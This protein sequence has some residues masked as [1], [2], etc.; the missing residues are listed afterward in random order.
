MQ[1]NQSETREQPA[2]APVSSPTTQTLIRTNIQ[3][4]DI[5]HHRGA[6]NIT[7]LK[8]NEC[9]IVISVLLFLSVEIQQVVMVVEW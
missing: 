5:Y 4:T 3:I 8:P 1:L 2:V 6:D 7:S 9:V